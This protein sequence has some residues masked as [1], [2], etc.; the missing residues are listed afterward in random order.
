MDE[1]FVVVMHGDRENLLGALL[2]DDISIELLFQLARGGNVGEERLGHAPPLALLVEDL[3]AELDAIAADINVAGTFH[4]RAHVAVALAAERAVGVL[5]GAARASRAHAPAAAI[6][7][8]AT[9]DEPPPV[10]SL[11]DGMRGPFVP[12]R[13]HFRSPAAAGDLHQA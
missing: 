3:L 12:I 11:P 6:A 1:P 5:L 7:L 2:A 10:M 9:P 4:Q 13:D 8:S